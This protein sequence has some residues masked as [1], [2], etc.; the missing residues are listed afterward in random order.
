M[1]NNGDSAGK[2]LT[3]SSKHE[4]SLGDLIEGM[5]NNGDLARKILTT[6]SMQEKS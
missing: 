5:G 6:S 3:T 2:I 1:G 4:K